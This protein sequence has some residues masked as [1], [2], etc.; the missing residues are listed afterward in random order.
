M[1]NVEVSEYRGALHG[2]DWLADLTGGIFSIE[3]I[4]DE[5]VDL[6]FAES[7]AISWKHFVPTK[8]TTY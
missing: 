8:F 5:G 6:G 3:F 4:N 7:K 1:L 2:Q